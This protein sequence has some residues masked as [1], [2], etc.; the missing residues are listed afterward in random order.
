MWK[1]YNLCITDDSSS[2]KFCSSQIFAFA[3]FAL[4]VEELD[5]LCQNFLYEKEN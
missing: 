5:N 2:F 1:V 3:N 4:T